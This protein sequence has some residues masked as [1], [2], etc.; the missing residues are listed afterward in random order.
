MY[1]GYGSTSKETTR[2]LSESVSVS[3]NNEELALKA[4]DS[5]RTQRDNLTSTQGHISG[6]RYAAEN[7]AI[8]IREI[9]N[10]T[11]RKK[12]CLW[13]IILAL[14]V[15]NIVVLVRLVKNGGILLAT[16][17]NVQGHTNNIHSV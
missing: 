15:A 17:T 11:L 2:L 3:R 4:G 1:K 16:A 5:L 9:E 6:M 8:S 10:R 14:F 7:A 12:M 13:S